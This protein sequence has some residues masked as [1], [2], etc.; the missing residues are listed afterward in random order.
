MPAETLLE[1]DYV[2]APL[3]RH[4]LPP[5]T[6]GAAAIVLAAGDKA[7]AVVGAPGV[8]HRVRPPDGDPRARGPGPD[9][10]RRR[11]PRPPRWPAWPTARSTWPRS[12]PPSPTRR[13]SC[14][15]ALGPR[16]LGGHQPV[17]RP[18]GRQ[19][20]HVGRPHP[21]RRG[22]RAGSASGE[23]RPGG[24]PRHLGA[25]ACNRTSSASWR[26]RDG[27]ALCSH[28]GGPDPPQGQ[29]GRRVHRRAGP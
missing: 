18:A 1:D 15:E 9:R 11:R 17:G 28:R 21:D 3:R 22:R 7:D 26:V 8:D 27:R 25:R 24:G 6:D 12:T 20:A 23:A 2:V 5:I 4:A 29:A 14:G 10:P 16:R 19:P 13:S